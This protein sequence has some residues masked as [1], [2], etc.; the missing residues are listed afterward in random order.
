MGVKVDK[1]NNLEKL[2]ILPGPLPLFLAIHNS[3]SIHS[4]RRLLPYLLIRLHHLPFN[5]PYPH[6][7]ISMHRNGHRLS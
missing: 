5:K 7:P 1:G 2:K 6:R 4:S 3:I